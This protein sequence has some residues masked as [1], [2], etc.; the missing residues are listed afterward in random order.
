MSDPDALRAEIDRPHRT[1]PSR[2]GAVAPLDPREAGPVG[3][4]GGPRD[5][6]DGPAQM[7]VAGS[8]VVASLI[9]RRIVARK[10]NP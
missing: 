6:A 8:L 2:P 4:A 10:K 1:W 3:C 9:L 5:S 7:V